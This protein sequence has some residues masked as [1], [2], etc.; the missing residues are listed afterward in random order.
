MYK[1]K[2]QQLCHIKSWNLPVY[3]TVKDGPDHN[4]GFISTVTVNGVQFQ[5]TQPTRTA[6]Q[7]QNDAAKLAF[8][9]FSSNPDPNPNPNSNF[10]L[11]PF[12]FSSP[13]PSLSHGSCDPCD[14]DSIVLQP[15]QSA[16]ISSS[17]TSTMRAVDQKNILHLYKNQLQNYAHKRN[18]NLPVY[19][20][21]WEGPPHALR[22]K[23]KVTID[24]QTFES[25]KLFATLKDAENAAAEVA[26]MSLSPGRAQEEQIGLYKN[27][28]QE[29]V[30]RK[31]FRLPSYNTKKYGEAH[32]PMFVSQVEVEGETFTGQAAKSK[33]Q[34]E[35][36]AAKVAYMSLNESKGASAYQGQAPVLSTDSS[37]ANVITVT[38]GQADKVIGV[39]AHQGQAPM[40]STECLE[41]N[42]ITGL[43]HHA[44]L[45][46]PVSFGLVT[47]D[48]S[49]KD[50]E[51]VIVT[52]KEGPSDTSKM[53]STEINTQ[54][55]RKNVVYSRNTN[56]NIEGG[57]TLMA[58][59]DEKWVAYS[60]SH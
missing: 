36:S 25:P 23:C 11:S 3:E 34:A 14:V 59:S 51:H 57:G 26:L 38:Q 1:T 21:V 15:T 48:Q 20:S 44:N 6:K 12:H 55:H 28:L 30:Q 32:M 52:E 7:S 47:Q 2:V 16:Q 43:Q 45:Q 18:L 4:P 8:Y 9:H 50:I 58:I 54:S 31:G 40:L 37:E 27:L 5:T 24:G 53:F 33:K 22:F 13:Q 41:A 17:V 56:V 29:L 39:S 19:A 60:Y 46:S 10:H 42:V 49:D 35:M